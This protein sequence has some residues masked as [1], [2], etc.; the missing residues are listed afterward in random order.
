MF[1]CSTI[2]L[3]M[4]SLETTKITKNT[5]KKIDLTHWSIWKWLS[6]VLE[7]LSSWKII[8]NIITSHLN[9]YILK[10]KNNI[11]SSYIQKK[12]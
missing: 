2:I 10:L 9:K 1:D 4:H 7:T 3:S 6:T 5:L 8:I 12:R 11:N